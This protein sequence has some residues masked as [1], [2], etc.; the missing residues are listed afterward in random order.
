MCPMGTLVIASVD[1]TVII[2]LKWQRKYFLRWSSIDIINNLLSSDSYY[3]LDDNT[4]LP[5]S[6]IEL[7]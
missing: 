3:I 4:C 1:V 2:Q 6:E 7:V 5:F